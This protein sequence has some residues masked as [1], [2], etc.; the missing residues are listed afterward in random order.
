LI[1]LNLSA[2]VPAPEPVEKRAV[3][4]E[5]IEDEFR[6]ACMDL[7]AFLDETRRSSTII[8]SELLFQAVDLLMPAERMAVV[9]GRRFG[10]RLVLGTFYDVTG[11]AHNAHVRADPRKLGQA[12]IAF[13][14][15]GVEI[16]GWIHSHPGGGPL[17]TAPSHIDRAQ[18]SEWVRDFS[19]K[20]VGI[21]VVRD[22]FVRLWGDAIESGAVRAD[23]PAKGVKT[24]QGH[25]H[26]Y[27]L[28]K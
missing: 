1:R 23:I 22:G 27:R 20:L 2:T 14:R 3:S 16:A 11:A 26:V 4:L 15:A 8:P 5:L 17:A 6:L 9:A 24:V 28:V 12:L 18:Y 13:E 7:A 19:R 21:I 10:G 25:R